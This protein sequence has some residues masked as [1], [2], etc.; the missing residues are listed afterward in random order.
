VRYEREQLAQTEASVQDM[1]LKF[2]WNQ[3]ETNSVLHWLDREA[4]DNV[5]TT[6]SVVPL[7][8][9]ILEN[10]VQF[11]S[12]LLQKMNEENINLG[13]QEVKDYLPFLTDLVIKCFEGYGEGSEKTRL[14]AIKSGVLI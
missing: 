14:V 10:V 3:S 4:S 7:C 5:R 2:G 12:F 8:Y 1:E 9:K 11:V 13:L 6:K